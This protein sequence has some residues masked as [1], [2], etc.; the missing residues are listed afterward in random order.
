MPSDPIARALRNPHVGFERKDHTDPLGRQLPYLAT[1]AEGCQEQLRDLSSDAQRWYVTGSQTLR[2]HDAGVALPTDL[3]R[4]R[5][6]SFR[7]ARVA[8]CPA[9][10]F[11]P[12]IQQ[13][14][15][16]SSRSVVRGAEG[17]PS[18]FAQSA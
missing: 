16:P 2:A 17:A 1:V 5:D 3:V 15:Q 8:R 18:L 13:L 12:Q 10:H 7:V 11:D 9:H 4:G 6:E 14:D